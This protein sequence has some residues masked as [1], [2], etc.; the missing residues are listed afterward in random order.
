[1]NKTIVNG[2]DIS[3]CEF[4]DGLDWHI[5]CCCGDLREDDISF[6]NLC[7]DNPDCYFKQLARIKEENVE[8]QKDCPKVCKSDSY[9]QA[10]ESIENY[11]NNTCA[12]SQ[13]TCDFYYSCS[14]C[15]RL[16][17]KELINKIQDIINKTKSSE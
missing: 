16:S 17:E 9:K 2:I 7:E 1:M 3:K 8:L 4:S 6:R 14:D 13:R 10:L 12:T 15:G 5:F 11:I